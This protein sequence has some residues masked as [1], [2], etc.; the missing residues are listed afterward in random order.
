M[1]FPEG[2]KDSPFNL[3]YPNAYLVLLS[4]HLIANILQQIEDTSGSKYF[5]PMKRIKWTRKKE[6]VFFLNAIFF[7]ECDTYIEIVSIRC[8][9]FN[10]IKFDFS[11]S[12]SFIIQS[13]SQNWAQNWYFARDILLKN[14]FDLDFLKSIIRKIYFQNKL[15]I[16]KNV[17]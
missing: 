13:G 10:G 6:Q 2:L 3:Q 7:C 4:S 16:I 17:F 8:M 11:K 1:Q 9:T 15:P 14:R 5:I 12:I